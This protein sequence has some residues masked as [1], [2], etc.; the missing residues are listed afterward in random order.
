MSE[1]PAPEHEHHWGYGG[2]GGFCT[3]CKIDKDE[4]QDKR[5]AALEAENA[6]M[7]AVVEAVARETDDATEWFCRRCDS[8]CLRY[9]GGT[10]MTLTHAADCL[11]TLARA[12]LA[13]A[14][15][16]APKEIPAT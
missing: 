12:V 4:W 14:S 2:D 6:R 1:I 3:I 11:V 15:N 13:S 8:S 10:R 9:E 5:I 16:T 7:R